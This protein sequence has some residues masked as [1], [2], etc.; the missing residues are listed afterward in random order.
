MSALSALELSLQ[1][2]SI[3]S[4]TSHSLPRPSPPFPAL[5][6][7]Q[8]QC[9]SPHPIPAGIKLDFKSLKAVGPSLDL[10]RQLTEAGRIRR[11][12]WINADILRGPN[13]PISIEINATQ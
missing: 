10:L 5:S 1:P 11:P 6:T 7:Q 12:V 13:V 8:V 4:P 2:I 3:C 9:P